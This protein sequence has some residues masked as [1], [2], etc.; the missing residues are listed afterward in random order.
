MTQDDGSP[1]PGG[2]IVRT[3]FADAKPVATPL[4]RGPEPGEALHGIE[5]GSWSKLKL[6][7]E[8]GLPPGCPVTPLGHLGSTGYFIDPAG[9]LQAFNKPYGKGDILALF[10]G[11]ANYLM[12]AWPR[13]GKDGRVDGFAAE[14]ANSILMSACRLKGIWTAQEKLLGRGMWK[15][16]GKELVFHAG[17]HL[18]IGGRE[19]PPGE[20]ENYVYPSRPAIPRPWPEKADPASIQLLM[21]ILRSW[22]WDRPEIDPILLAG[23]LGAAWLGSAVEQR[24]AA[25]ILGDKAVG[26]STLQALVKMLFGG[27][28]IQAGDTTAAGIYQT[29]GQDCLPVAIDEFESKPDPRKAAAIV[30]LARV[31]YS[32]G[33]LRRGGDRHDSVEF[34][35]RSAFLFSA[36]NMPPFHPQDLSRTIML[37]LRPLPHDQ[38]D[39][40]LN[41][42]WLAMIGRMILRR[43]MDEWYR[44]E[45]TYKAFKAELAAGRMDSR[46]REN[47]GRL[48]TC[49]DMLFH[50]GWD[51]E[52]LRHPTS[53]GELV[54]W[55]ELLNPRKMIEFE[56]QTE[57]WRLCLDQM[58]SV[59]VDAWRNG[60][61]RTVGQVICEFYENPAEMPLDQARLLLS[62]AGLTIVIRNGD[63]R[64]S[65]RR[66][67]GAWL[68]VPN[69]DAL[70]RALFKDSKWYG[71]SNAGTWSFALRQA[72]RAICE[73]NQ[74]RINGRHGRAV[75]ISL[76]ALYGPTG[77]MAAEVDSLSHTL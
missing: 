72:P 20:F 24:P 44:Y 7:D 4:S 64:Q 57:N 49:Y 48:L 26:K 1:A 68:A 74:A 58:L 37:Q 51:E 8:W 25:F 66:P 56:G 3:L 75:L 38:P 11:D 39:V 19:R 60:L 31:S 42:P 76:E 34:Q 47:F 77:I 63:T 71:E 46:G 14:D 73:P 10:L 45:E 30:E 16:A 2:A 43:I 54:P 59:A 36:I 62:Q 18:H 41:E 5:A 50:D 69:Q 13:R 9:Q 22:N 52:R 17:M 27:A 12:W 67:G 28:L 29:L 65:G 33:K 70:T 35:L 32:G 6:A 23:W 21:P 40:I 53:D 55:R 15:S 61:R